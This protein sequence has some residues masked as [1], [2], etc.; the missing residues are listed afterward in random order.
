MVGSWSKTNEILLKQKGGLL[1]RV[2]PKH[3]PQC[4]IF[5]MMKHDD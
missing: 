1:A 4:F 3:Q 2:L 5:S